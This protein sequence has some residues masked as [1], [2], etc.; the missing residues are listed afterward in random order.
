MTNYGKANTN[1]SQFVITSVS[2]NNLDETN[3]V[4]GKVLR[5]L[6]IINDMEQNVD[7]EGNPN[8]VRHKHEMLQRF[9]F[10]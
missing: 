10:N 4:V 7:D 8:E 6:A 5:G 2:C 3:V 9:S 1:N